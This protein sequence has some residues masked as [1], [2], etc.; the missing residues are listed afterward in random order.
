MI[1]VGAGRRERVFQGTR[2]ER[3]VSRRRCVKS[4]LGGWSAAY[5]FC[6]VQCAL[7]AHIF[8][9]KIR[10]HI[11]RGCNNPVYYV[12]KNVGAHYT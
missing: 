3:Q 8:E 1:G 11:I 4:C 7:F 12:H 2:G 6:C 5:I 10:M 9:G